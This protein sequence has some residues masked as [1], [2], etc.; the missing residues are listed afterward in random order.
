MNDRTYDIDVICN[1]CGHSYRVGIPVG[2][3]ALDYLLSKECPYCGCKD[4]RK[5]II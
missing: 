2:E 3:R 5:N 4:L 1:N